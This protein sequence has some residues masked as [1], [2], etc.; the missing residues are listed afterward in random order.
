MKTKQKELAVKC[1]TDLGVYK[2]YIKKFEEETGSLIYAV[3]HEYFS[4]GECY[5]CLYISKC[6]EDWSYC[7]D[8]IKRGLAWAWV[9]NKTADYCSEYGTVT[10]KSF[11]GGLMRLY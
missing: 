2:P 8:D 10:I 9:W 3:T 6:E 11:G 4:F 5:T 7:T 1:L